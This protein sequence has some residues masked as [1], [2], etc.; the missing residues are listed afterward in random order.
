MTVTR[1]FLHHM[2]VPDDW[3]MFDIYGL[4]EQEL[5]MVPLPCASVI[6]LFPFNDAYENRR[7]EEELLIKSKGQKVSEDLYYIKQYVGN[8]C[9]TIA[10]LHS[11]ANN[12][13]KIEL[14]E[15]LLKRFL[16]EGENLSP[17]DRGHLLEKNEEMS[18]AHKEVAI[19]GQSAAPDPADAVPYH[20]VAFVCKDN[21]L[22]E[23]DGRKFEPI[24]HG[25]SN[26]DSI[27]VDTVKVIQE[28]F[29]APESGNIHFTLLAMSNCSEEI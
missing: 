21:S 28:K 9:G 26:P 10:L 13:D 18:N 16:D 17:S 6:M 25:P 3:N 15:G 29:I 11:V 5:A 19:D 7:N 2:G 12:R 24:N 23:L 27:L 8:A 4:G 14:K 20:F 22:Y 1:M